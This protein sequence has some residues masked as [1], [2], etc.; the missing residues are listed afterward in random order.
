[1]MLYEYLFLL[2]S[3]FNS[4]QNTLNVLSMCIIGNCANKIENDEYD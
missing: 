4:M 1:M 2:A 3:L